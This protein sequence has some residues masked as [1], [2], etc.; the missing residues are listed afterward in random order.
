M[1]WHTYEVMT[2]GPYCVRPETTLEETVRQF[3]IKNISAA[4]VLNSDDEIIGLIS[5]RD[6]ALAK[7]EQLVKEVMSTP[8]V[9]ID[10]AA[11]M[12]TVLQRF[13]SNK[14][15]RLVVVHNERPIGI[16]SLVDLLEPLI[17]AYGFPNFM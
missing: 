6:V 5:L 10:H 2:P 15:H 13:K 3:Q 8:A 9:C 17:E 7:P 1:K 14:M 16:I 4:P 11:T 12:P